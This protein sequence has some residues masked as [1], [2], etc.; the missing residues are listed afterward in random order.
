MAK[1]DILGTQGSRGTTTR[2]STAY[3]YTTHA[4]WKRLSDADRAGVFKVLASRRGFLSYADYNRAKRSGWEDQAERY[5]TEHSAEATRVRG[6]SV[7]LFYKNPR[8]YRSSIDLA[9]TNIRRD[10]G[11][12]SAAI[13]EIWRGV[14]NPLDSA[15]DA[16]RRR[17]TGLG[18]RIGGITTED[19]QGQTRVDNLGN[20]QHA[21]DLL[22]AGTT[23]CQPTRR[24][25]V[26]PRDGCCQSI[27]CGCS[28]WWTTTHWR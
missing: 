7:P 2:G 10:F 16:D 18:A 21:F 11:H 12:V 22:G 6:T 14:D 15:L 20:L 13:D 9:R 24:K 23:H 3:D 26:N 8:A 4:V 19:T 1:P 5:Y 27:P 17:G 25:L 28:C